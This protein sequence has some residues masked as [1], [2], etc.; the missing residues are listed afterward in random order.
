VGLL[1]NFIYLFFGMLLELILSPLFLCFCDVIYN[2]L[3]VRSII[4]SSLIS[5]MVKK[6]KV[7]LAVHLMNCISADINL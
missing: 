6:K 2:L 1:F 3:L 4:L 5:L 7:Q